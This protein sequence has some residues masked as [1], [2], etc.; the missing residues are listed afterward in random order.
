MKDLM[1]T[2]LLKILAI[3]SLIPSYI[4]AGGAIGYGLDKWFTTFPFVTG[5]GILIGFG[6]AVRDMMRLKKEW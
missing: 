1:S 4:V 3:W 6:L 2:K 5:A